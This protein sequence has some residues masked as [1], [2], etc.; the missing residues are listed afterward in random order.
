MTAGGPSEKAGVH[1]DSAARDATQYNGD[2]DLVIA[3]DG[4]ETKV[5]SD[6]MSYI[7]NH[8]RPGQTVTLTLLR[9]GQKMDVP[10]TLGER[11]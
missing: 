8:A 11:P 6:M 10:V 7:I 1:G 4:H 2:G 9:G 5:F 3:I